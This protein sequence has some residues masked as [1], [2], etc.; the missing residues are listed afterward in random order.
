[1]AGT[2]P[3]QIRLTSIVLAAIAAGV[4]FFLG[5]PLHREYQDF[6]SIGWPLT[7]HTSWVN[8]DVRHTQVNVEGLVVDVALLLSGMYFACLV[9]EPSL[10]AT[11]E[12]KLFAGAMVVVFLGCIAFAIFTHAIRNW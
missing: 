3:I 6:T 10:L 8:D 1:V 2:P 12:R 7:A 5:R 9:S 11:A 4:F